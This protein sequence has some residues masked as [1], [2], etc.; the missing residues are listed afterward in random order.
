MGDQRF[1]EI[2]FP[3]GRNCLMRYEQALRW[4]AHGSEVIPFVLKR[5]PTSTLP[6]PREY[7]STPPRARVPRTSS[8]SA[9]GTQTSIPASASVTGS[10]LLLSL[11]DTDRPTEGD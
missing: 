8:S 9:P 3:I 6:S 5:R 10:S 1:F 7:L 2:H 11:A 4:P